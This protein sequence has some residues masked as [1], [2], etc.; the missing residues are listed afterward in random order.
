MPADY[1]WQMEDTTLCQSNSEHICTDMPP[2]TAVTCCAGSGDPTTFTSASE[3]GCALESE[4]VAAA[5]READIERMQRESCEAALARSQEAAD[6]L[7]LKLKAC[8]VGAVQ[9]PYGPCR[10][11]GL[12][13]AVQLQ[14]GQPSSNLDCTCNMHAYIC[15]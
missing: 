4:A 2:L 1:G 8:Q 6:K 12:G 13:H 11:G 15:A 5:V 14:K 7:R 9:G 10:H 3:V